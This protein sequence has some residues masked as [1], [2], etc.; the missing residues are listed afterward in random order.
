MAKP[1][2]AAVNQP[3]DRAF[4][5]NGRDFKIESD[6]DSA[7]AN[8]N[9]QTSMIIRVFYRV[10]GIPV[11]HVVYNGRATDS[12]GAANSRR[13]INDPAQTTAFRPETKTSHSVRVVAWDNV[14]KP[15]NGGDHRSKVTHF[16]VI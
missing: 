8:N 9:R 16:L 7:D 6:G 2:R 15:G 12:V 4:V 14:N 3:G 1:T 13:F 5:A 11:A 10:N